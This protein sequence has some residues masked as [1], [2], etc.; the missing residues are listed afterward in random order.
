[1]ADFLHV[2]QDYNEN[3]FSVFVFFFLAGLLLISY[4]Y[5]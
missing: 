4:N 5:Y 3:K 1:M 2:T